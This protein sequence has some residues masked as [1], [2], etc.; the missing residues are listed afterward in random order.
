VL[1]CLAEALPGRDETIIEVSDSEAKKR[2]R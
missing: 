2:Q 1:I